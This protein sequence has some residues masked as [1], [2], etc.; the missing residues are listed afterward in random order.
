MPR[1]DPLTTRGS[2]LGFA[3]HFLHRRI[4]KRRPKK[5]GGG[6]EAVPAIPPRG[7]L[8]LQGGAEAPLEFGD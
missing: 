5:S 8:P 7:P 3:A 1:H 4:G 6:S 2:K